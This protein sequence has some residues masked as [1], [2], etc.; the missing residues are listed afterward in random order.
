[1]A[2]N[3]HLTSGYKSFVD[4]TSQLFH[5]IE[6]V[7]G[8]EYIPGVKSQY[9]EIR[10]KEIEFISMNKQVYAM[11]RQMLELMASN[12]E[13]THRHCWQTMLRR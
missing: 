11:L 5:Q 3:R 8:N 7:E 2:G 6:R 13:K 12:C 9:D 10:K 4:N 1:M